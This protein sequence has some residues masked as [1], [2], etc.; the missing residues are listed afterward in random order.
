MN[1]VARVAGLLLAVMI[2]ATAPAEAARRKVIIDQ[3]AFE[4]PGL[5]PILMVLQDPT[6][7][8]LGITIVSGDGWAKEE[9]SQTL[10]M[11]ELVGRTD[12]PVLLG[13]TYPLVN[14]QAT[15][16]LRE[17]LY[18]P[19]PYK[20]AWMEEWPS[21]NAMVRRAWHPADVVPS[22][23]EGA[24][25]AKVAEE[26]AAAFLLRKTREF[27]GQVSI[28][29]MGPLTNLALAQRI[30][31]GFAA[32]TQEIVLIG[33]G[34][35]LGIDIDKPQDEFAM[36]LVFSPRQ[37]FNFSWDP[38]AAHIVLTSAWPK[39]TMVTDDATA[40]T[41]GTADLIAKAT[42]SGR[43]V[44][45]YVKRTAQAGFP[46]WDETQ[47]AVWLDPTIVTRSSTLA[48]DVS[49]L[50]GPH[51]GGALTWAAGKGPGLGERDVTIIHGV[52]VA[53]L[54]RMFVELLGR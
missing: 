36:Q 8:V 44:A 47:A 51:Y 40:P 49:T 53:K 16:K 2:A 52:D 18:G 1:R 38:E 33:G 34:H 29:A 10:R 23:A 54:D 24:P 5:Q 9:A 11:L 46:L 3:D 27:P 37:S 30:D 32:R 19:I 7:E 17:K 26:N 31:D 20:G 4:G 43:P 6:V 35:L 21:Y 25:K 42:A 39:I 45:R 15:Q 12:I 13:A 48:V 41:R 28:I 14:S 50:A 22:T